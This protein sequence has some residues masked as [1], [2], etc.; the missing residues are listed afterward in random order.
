MLRPLKSPKVP[1]ENSGELWRLPERLT[2]IHSYRQCPACL[3][4][5]IFCPSQFPGPLVLGTRASSLQCCWWTCPCRCEW[6]TPSGCQT[7]PQILRGPSR[8]PHMSP[9]ICASGEN[10]FARSPLPSRVTRPSRNMLNC[11][12]QSSYLDRENSFLPIWYLPR[13]KVSLY[14]ILWCPFG[15]SI[16]FP[17]NLRGTLLSICSSTPGPS[18][19]LWNSSMS[20]NT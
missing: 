20:W 5:W 15:M 19:H 14:P 6:P 16:L 7:L 10:M 11:I 13:S 17:H 8:L 3:A 12:K 2:Q 1:P 18:L 9:S 4:M